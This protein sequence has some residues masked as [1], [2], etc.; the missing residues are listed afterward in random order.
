MG[1]RVAGKELIFLDVVDRSGKIQFSPSRRASDEVSLGDIVGIEGL[2]TKTK[3]GEP[4]LTVEVVR[5]PRA[6]SRP[7][8]PTRSTA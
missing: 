6:D 2:L 1:R 3:R 8:C 5:S 7:R 4:S